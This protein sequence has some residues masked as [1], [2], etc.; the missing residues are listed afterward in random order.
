MYPLLSVRFSFKN[1]TFMAEASE[2][3]NDVFLPT[4]K[5]FVGIS[6]FRMVGKTGA[7]ASFVLAKTNRVDGDVTHWEF[8]PTQETLKQIPVLANHRAVILND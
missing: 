8:V 6:T 5:N 3:G 1:K 2:L 7:V 4:R